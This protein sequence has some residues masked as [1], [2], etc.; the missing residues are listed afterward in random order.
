M[1]GLHDSIADVFGRCLLGL[2][3]SGPATAQGYP[4]RPITMIVPFAGGRRHRY[5]GALPGRANAAD[6][7]PA[8]D[9]RECGGSGWQPRRHPRRALGRR[10]LHAEH[11]HL[12]H[13]HA[14]RR[15]LR[16]AVRSPEGSRADHPDRQRAAVDRRQERPAGRRSEG[17]DRL[18]EGK[19]RQGV[20]RHRRRRRHRPSHRNFV[21]EGDRNQIPVHAL[22]RQRPGDAGPGCPGRSIS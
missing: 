21:P 15:P 11:R 1:G 8:R 22:S 4:A 5:A 17:P 6:S 16:A 7:R 20:G 3:S 18:A 2:A 10:R 19:S 12:D 9:H 14:D 13:A